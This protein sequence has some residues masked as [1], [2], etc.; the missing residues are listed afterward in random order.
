MP[1]ILVFDSGIGGTSV[2]SE[3][4]LRLPDARYSYVMDNA[5]LPYGLQSQETIT[6]RLVSLLF[7]IHQNDVNVDIIVIACNTASTYALETARKHTE[8]P[9]VGVVPA[10]KPAALSSTNKH[11]G[12]LAT[13]ATSKNAYTANLIS[14]FAQGCKV[15][16]HH[17]TE[18]VNIAE[19]YYWHRELPYERLKEELKRLKVDPR[20]DRLVLGCT[21]FPIIKEALKE[22][23]H[24]EV[25][26]VDSGYAIAKRVE[27]LLM[28]TGRLSIVSS[29][30]AIGVEELASSQID[31][32]HWYA[33]HTN[34]AAQCSKLQ[35]IKLEN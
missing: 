25:E 21:H 27:Y 5:L 18:L 32:T 1:H 9:I 11:I 30:T 10:I 33:T 34:G 26:L 17:S 7:W 2:L 22:L 28:Q 4:Q 31:M 24:N 20:L 14:N 13:P 3:L 35:L 6:N 15:D 19:S 16:I 12:L 23:L 8:I 29:Q